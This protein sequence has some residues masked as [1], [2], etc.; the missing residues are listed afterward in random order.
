MNT[1][2]HLTREQLDTDYAAMDASPQNGGTVEL[3]VARPEADQRSLLNE[4]ELNTEVG[5]VGDSWLARGSSSTDD[6]SAN[7]EAQL[8][9]MN[10]RIAQLVAGDKAHWPLAGDQLYVDLDLSIDN[11]P[12]GQRVRI[13]EALIEISALPHTGCKK[14]MA[15]FGEDA[16]AFISTPTGKANRMRGVNCRVI[17]AGRIRVG[18]RLEK[19]DS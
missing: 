9:L 8:T 15:R 4:A 1:I 10:S 19:V 2:E 6:G 12:P 3:I 5:L 18:D 14:F 7:P 16:L 13:G 11:L 17:E